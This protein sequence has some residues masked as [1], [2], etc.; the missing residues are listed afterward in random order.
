MN[1]IINTETKRLSDTYIAIDAYQLDRKEQLALQDSYMKELKTDRLEDDNWNNKREITQQIVIL[2]QKDPRNYLKDFVNIESPYFG[3]VGIHDTDKAIG[4]KEYIIG[5]QSLFNGNKSLITDWRNI[6]ITRFYYEYDEGDDYEE[7]IN[8]RDRIGLITHKRKVTISKKSLVG[9][10][11]TDDLYRYTNGTWLSK[12]GNEPSTPITADIKTETG[13]HHLIDI[14]ALISPQQFATITNKREGCTYLT[15]GAGSGKTTVAEHQ[16]SYL[17]YNYKELFRQERCLFIVFNKPLNDYVRLSSKELLGDTHVS[18]FSSWAK[19]AINKLGC[20]NFQISTENNVFDSIKKSS[21]L[22]QLLV[23]YA[24]NPTDKSPI[25]DLFAFYTST[26]V[27]ECFS[28]G[29]DMRDYYNSYQKALDNGKPVISFNDLGPLLRLC[30]LRNKQEEVAKAYNYYDYIIGDEAQDFSLIELEALYTALGSRKSMTI[31]ADP[32]QKILSD[33]DSTGLERFINNLQTFGLDKTILT[34][35]YRSAP[36]IMQIANIVAGKIEGTLPPNGHGKIVSILQA[37]E[38]DQPKI[39]SLH[40]TITKI[41][42]YQSNDP[43][44]LTAIICKTKAECNYIHQEISK[45]SNHGIKNLHPVG[46]ILFTPGVIITN[47]H[48]V[49][50]LEFTNV[51]IWNPS[52]RAYRKTEED[53]NLLYVAISRACKKLSIIYY[54]N[55]SHWLKTT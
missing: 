28:T 39:D 37:T 21:E 38:R 23:D 34:V 33:V 50:G 48:Q 43:T 45:L 36:E 32:K 18:T 6:G 22:S 40:E 51:I 25:E 35:G 46:L 12:N 42:E 17:Q 52:S 55:L 16:L 5:K 24:K 20:T 2:D 13:N 4:I 30:Q 47:A 1:D 7:E 11:T 27:A 29:K 15:G 8:G 19:I 31:C 26:P 54:E 10:E 41:H 53:R 14:V 9:I 44:S 49:K 3:I